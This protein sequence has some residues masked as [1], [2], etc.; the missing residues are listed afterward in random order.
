MLKANPVRNRRFLNGVNQKYVIGIDGGGTKTVAALSDLSGKILKI[1]K[2]GPTSPRNIGIKKTVDNVAKSIKKVLPK[3]KAKI[4]STFIGLPAVEEEFRLKKEIIKKEL[5]RYKKIS[6]IFS[7]KVIIGS[8]QIVAFRSGS[9]RKDGV[10]LIA[11][12]GCVAHGWRGNQKVK[13]SGWGWLADEGSAFWV[14]QKVYQAVLKDLDGRGSKTL[15]R[16]LIFQEHKIKEDPN[17]LNKLIYSKPPTEVLS[18]LSFICDG[19]SRKRDKIAREILVEAGRE[20]ALSAETVIKK[21]NFQE[22]RFP[23]VLVGSMFNSKIVLDT[24]KKEVKKFTLGVEFIRPKVEPVIGA[25]RLAIEQ[26][27]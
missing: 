23:L 16:K 6:L 12:T 11:G 18:L 19:A 10:L 9:D 4:L 15:L 3:K 5:L 21:L 27:Q 14:G 26:I 2:S 8:D 13:T 22:T 24:V 7:G 25:V 1:G 17:L 20:L